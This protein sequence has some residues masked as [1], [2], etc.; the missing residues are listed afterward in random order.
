M[1]RIV[2]CGCWTMFPPSV[3]ALLDR[4]MLACE[5]EVQS[6]LLCGIE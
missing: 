1:Q 5:Q 6:S 4:V 3:H 2:Y